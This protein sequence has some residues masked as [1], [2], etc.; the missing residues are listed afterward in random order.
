MTHWQGVMNAMAHTLK[1]EKLNPNPN[2]IP[3]FNPFF[4]VVCIQ[5]S[6]KFKAKIIEKSVWTNSFLSSRLA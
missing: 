3:N 6:P 1:T 2:P 4:Q 5:S